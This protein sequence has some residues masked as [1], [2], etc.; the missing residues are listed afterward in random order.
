M[1]NNKFPAH[2]TMRL[3]V[4]GQLLIIEGSGPANIEM[5]QEYQQKVMGLRKQIMHAPWASLALLSG[6]PLVSP[7]AKELFVKVIKQAKTMHLRA[8]AVVL[9]DMESADMVRQFWQ[10][11]YIDAGVKYDFFETIEE[12]RNWLQSVL[13]NATNNN[14]GH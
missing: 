4:E 9:I 8:T 6:T 7:E 10:E 3:S 13:K 2:G 11:I 5:V 1:S 14:L 12:A